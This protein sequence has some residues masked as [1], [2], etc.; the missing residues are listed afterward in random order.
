[1]AVIIIIIIIRALC[2]LVLYVVNVLYNVH[3]VA[4]K[5]DIERFIILWGTVQI[6]NNRVMCVM[7]TRY[8]SYTTISAF[9]SV[10]LLRI[11]R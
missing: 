8:S 5:L 4:T 2:T 11:I 10:M 1:M 6:N 3:V 7:L 9:N